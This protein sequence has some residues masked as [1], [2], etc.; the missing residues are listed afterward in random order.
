MR[1]QPRVFFQRSIAVGIAIRVIGE[2]NFVRRRFFARFCRRRRSWGYTRQF[3]RGPFRRPEF[4]P[5]QR[6]R[7]YLTR[8]VC[9]LQRLEL[10]FQLSQRKRN[11]HL[12]R[13]KECLNKK[14]ASEKRK[15]PQNQ[16]SEAQ[17]R[18]AFAGRVRENKR[19]ECVWREFLHEP[20]IFAQLRNN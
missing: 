8:G 11:P 15:H 5:K 3:L 17:S 19:R 10:P 4:L 2:T 20:P 12:R 7:R 14:D 16:Q 9:P 18:P 13:D 6:S 1:D